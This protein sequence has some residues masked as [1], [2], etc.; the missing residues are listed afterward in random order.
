L[1]LP[2]PNEEV[3]RHFIKAVETQ[4]SL[5]KRNKS[6]SL[7]PLSVDLGGANINNSMPNRAAVLSL[8][9]N[10]PGIYMGN[11]VLKRVGPRSPSN[12]S[13]TNADD[14]QAGGALQKNIARTST[15]TPLKSPSGS[16]F[17]ILKKQPPSKIPLK[18]D[19]N[20]SLKSPFQL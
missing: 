18:L 9:S 4:R 5:A 3:R 19:E 7:N 12:I 11:L 2:E 15:E 13:V 14:E 20:F 6:V 8:M 17:E 1:G 16:E 10:T